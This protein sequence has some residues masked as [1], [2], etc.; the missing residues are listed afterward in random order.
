MTGD[1]IKTQLRDGSQY[2]CTGVV[3]FLQPILDE[4]LNDHPAIRILLRGDS[5]FATPDLYEQCEENDTGYVI[6]LKEDGILRERASCLVDEL[7]EITQNNKVNHAAVYGDFMYRAGSWS[8]ERRV[9][10]K[11]EKLKDQMVYMY[12]FLVTNMDPS[13]E[14]LIR[15]Y[16]KRGQ[17]KNFIKESE[18]GFDLASVSSHTK[19]RKC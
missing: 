17:M 11:V 19:A 2:S 4:Y 15:F 9:V 18:S 13:H 10:C 5:G 6:R 7:D 1:L 3:D 12:T 8:Y 16:C 14:D